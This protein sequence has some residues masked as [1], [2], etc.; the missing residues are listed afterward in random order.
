MPTVDC[1]M[2]SFWLLP[3]F[4]AFQHDLTGLFVPAEER[5]VTLQPL[6]AK[7]ISN[8]QTVLNTSSSRQDRGPQF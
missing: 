3:L 6:A 8:H 5:E 4:L 7:W 1:Q 2:G